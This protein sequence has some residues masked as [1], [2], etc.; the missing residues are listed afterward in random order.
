MALCIDCAPNYLVSIG[1]PAPPYGPEAGG[2]KSPSSKVPGRGCRSPR[3]T[4]EQR[5]RWRRYICVTGERVTESLEG[6]RP[7][8]GQVFASAAPGRRRRSFPGRSW[9]APSPAAWCG[10]PGGPSAEGVPTLGDVL[11][12]RRLLMSPVTFY[13]SRGRRRWGTRLCA[14]AR[15]EGSSSQDLYQFL[16]KHI[17]RS[18]KS[19]WFLNA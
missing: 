10:W 9:S 18:I 5:P 13:L 7:A 14:G 15:S 6:V 8:A 11:K 3:A 19:Y 4:G 1:G 12:G 16:I 2:D 17:S